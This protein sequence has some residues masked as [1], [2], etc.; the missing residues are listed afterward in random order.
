MKRIKQI[1]FTL[2]FPLV[3]YLLMEAACQILKG[4]H[5]IG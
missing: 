4:R 1:L 5:L 3:M 2:A